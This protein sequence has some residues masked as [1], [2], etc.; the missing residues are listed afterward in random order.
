M[1]SKKQHKERKTPFYHEH[2]AQGAMMVPFAGW[3]MPLHYGSQ[4]KEHEAVRTSV[5]M[6]DVSHMALVDVKG[7]QATQYLRHVLANDVA[8]LSPGRALY[9]CMLNEEGGILDDLITYQFG[10]AHYRLIVNAATTTKDLKWLEDH[11]RDFQVSLQHLTQ[12][13]LLAL[14]GPKAKGILAK[15]LKVKPELF[16]QLKPFHFIEVDS[17]TI[18][19]T[20]YTGEE[21]VEIMGLFDDLLS[22]FKAFIE[23]GVSPCGLGARDTLRLEAG[24][25]LYGQDMD[26]TTTPFESNLGWTVDLKDQTRSFVG[27][28][29]LLIQKEQGIPYELIS[30]VFDESG[31]LRHDMAV[32]LD[33]DDSKTG[34]ITSGSYAPTIKKSIAFARIPKVPFETIEVNM[35]GQWR[36]ARVVKPPFVKQGKICITV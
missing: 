2:V 21:G 6:F 35:R 10:P 29:A 20:G 5:G 34:V 27:K 32:R 4:L 31:I 16:T 26:E 9:G 18:A 7:E 30:V 19:S 12:L 36:K 28:N 22:L 24:L 23:A 14:Q 1:I 17:L 33:Q 25:N 15:V 13:G 3:L 11:K 8:K